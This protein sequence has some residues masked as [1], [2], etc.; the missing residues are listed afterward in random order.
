MFGAAEGGQLGLEGAH[1]R[2]EDELAVIEHAGNRGIDGTAETAALRGH[3][4]E[5]NNRR[6]GSLDSY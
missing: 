5:R 6:I 1:F 3:V 2:T 4:D